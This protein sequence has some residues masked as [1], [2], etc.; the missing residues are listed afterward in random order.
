MNNSKI[1]VVIPTYK[2][3][4]HILDVI[5]RIGPEVE[6]VMVVDDCCP[7]RTGDW[8]AK[9]CSDPRVQIIHHSHNQ[10]VGGAV[11]TGYEAA[12]QAG[13]Q[14]LVKI[15]S[16]GQMD[17]KL[18]GYFVEP[19]LAGDADYTKGNRFYDIEKL[20]AMPRVRLIGNAVL[21]LMSKVSTGYWNL[22]DPT[23]GYTA[24]HANVAKK[25]PFKKISK[26]YFFE[27]DI[28]F[29]LNTLRAVVIDVPMEAKYGDEQSHL[30]INKI[31]L[32]FAY[33]HLKNT[34]KRI[35]YNY[36]LRDMSLASL[37]LPL[38]LILMLF[39]GVYGAYHWLESLQTNVPTNP[40][41]VML[42]GLPVLSGLQLILSFVGFDVQSV[43]SKVV[44][45]KL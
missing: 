37:Q 18:I 5:A 40:G 25:L 33:K 7:D 12:I 10:G 36:Y 27:S 20:R 42:S 15:D 45:K 35:F 38:G 14:V 4:N 32:E 24:I 43:P 1:A 13:A 3:K 11:L 34:V 39:G 31:I 2:A 41:T 17:P 23:N 21:S 29:R 26:R 9:N 19:I 16:D 28:L 22:F 8:L 30:K 44:H 6:W